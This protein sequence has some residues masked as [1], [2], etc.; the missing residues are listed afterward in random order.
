MGIFI[1]PLAKIHGRVLLMTN[2]VRIHMPIGMSVFIGSVINPTPMQ[3]FM[4]A[5]VAK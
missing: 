3:G 4:M 1:N 5:P 2:P